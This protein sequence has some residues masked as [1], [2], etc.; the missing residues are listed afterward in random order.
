MGLAGVCSTEGFVNRMRCYT[1]DYEGI[2]PLRSEK[3][4]PKCSEDFCD[5]CG[6]C[7]ACCE[8]DECIVSG[9]GH[10]WVRY[11]KEV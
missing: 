3:L 1:Y 8:K 6:E 4:I 10:F 5:S 2:N 11:E 9:K 7:L